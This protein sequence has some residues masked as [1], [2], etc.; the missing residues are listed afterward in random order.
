[1]ICIVTPRPCLILALQVD[2]FLDAENCAYLFE[3]SSLVLAIEQMINLINN[4]HVLLGAGNMR[5]VLSF[6]ADED[7]ELF[8]N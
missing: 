8:S 5:P 6:E 3:P 2:S 4:E 7:L 1:M